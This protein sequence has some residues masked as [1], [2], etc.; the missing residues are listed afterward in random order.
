MGILGFDDCK[1]VCFE[2]IGGVQAQKLVVFDDKD[3]WLRALIH[4]VRRR[5]PGRCH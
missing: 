5:G 2:E 4:V 1:S 3:Q